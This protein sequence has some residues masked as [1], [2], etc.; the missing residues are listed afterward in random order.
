MYFINKRR[1][2]AAL[3]A[4]PLLALA[5]PVPAEWVAS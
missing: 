2:A 4:V 5:A 3:I 1:A